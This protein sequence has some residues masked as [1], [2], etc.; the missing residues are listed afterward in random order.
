MIRKLWYL[1]AA[2]ET[3]PGA[4]RSGVYYFLKGWDTQIK[5]AMIGQVVEGSGGS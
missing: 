2:V 4:L 5:V 3:L 1:R